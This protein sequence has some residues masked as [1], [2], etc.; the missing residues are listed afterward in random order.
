MPRNNYDN[1]E[2]MR[3]IIPVTQEHRS[4]I[5]ESVESINAVGGSF[6]DIPKIT[7]VSG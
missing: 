7:L 4:L 3:V 1:V 5:L 6:I 2:D